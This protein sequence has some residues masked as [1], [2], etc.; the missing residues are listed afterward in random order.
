MRR[1]KG[2]LARLVWNLSYILVGAVI[3][4]G[5][6]W[7]IY[8]TPRVALVAVVG[9]VLG[10]GIVLLGRRLRWPSII[11]GAVSVIAYVLVVVPVAIPTALSSPLRIIRGVGEGVIGIVVG[12]KQLLTLTLPVGDY[13]A[14]LVPLLVVMLFGTLI[15]TLLV[16]GT[17]RFSAAA[18][19]VVVLMAAF[20][21]VFGSSETGDP[22]VIGAVVVPAP[23][24][25]LLSTV[26]VLVSLVWLVGSARLTRARALRLAQART[27]GV[28]QGGESFWLTAR[29]QALAIVLVGLA[30]AGGIA[31]APVAAGW[32]PRQ[33]LRDSVDPLIVVQQQTSP[34]SRY[35]AN[36]E[37]AAYEAE[38]FRI[39]G[40]AAGI[41]RVRMAT[42]GQ[43][44]GQVFRSGT[45]TGDQQ[46]TRLPQAGQ[47][48]GTVELS[49]TIGEG[50]AG[51]WVPVPGRLDG[52]PSF[53]GARAEQLTD[54]FYVARSDGSAV[55]VAE[56]AGGGFG[57]TAGD[58]YS[59]QAQAEA[60]GA[61]LGDVRGGESLIDPDD[62]V[63]LVNWV[64]VQKQ[65]R[66]G[67][68]LTELVSRLRDRGYLS[69]SLVESDATQQWISA[70]D[71]QSPYVF[72]SSYS[73]HSTARIETLFTTLNAQER[74][75]GPEAD[76]ELLVSAIGDDEQFA[77]A[78][79]LLARFYGF[80]S[81]V[82][83]GTVLSSDEQN[84]S[85][86]PCVDGVCTGANVTAWVEVQ[87]PQGGWVVLDASPQ[88]A[89]APTDVAEGEEL[90]ENPTVPQTSE[91]D[92][93]DPPAAQRDDAEAT[94][95]GADD[96]LGWLTGLLGV[97]A[98]V[99][100]IALAVFLLLLPLTFLFFIKSFRRRGRRSA[101]V[102]EV[103]IVGA[104]DELLDTY[105]DYGV[106]IPTTATRSAIAQDIGR[107]AVIRLAAIVD[108]AVFAEHPPRREVRDTAWSIVDD[109]RRE[110]A[111]M[112]NFKDR[113]R[114]WISLAS[115]LRHISPRAVLVAGLSVLRK[116]ETAR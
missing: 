91:A 41:S 32:S 96:G 3:A 34:L 47:G 73:G 62:Y 35:R 64:E 57:L 76:D 52:A 77:T 97:L 25:V 108:G 115:F 86:A 112:T 2:G 14:V 46:Y 9:T 61:E 10:I 53:T 13:Q 37:G 80:E 84:P 102:P 85:V 40:D 30:V 8:S 59:V 42:L 109:E 29:R 113:V 66:T 48:E 83:L 71:A 79:A 7:P 24:E 11:I 15:A 89:I 78:A 28:R 100:T 55:D 16:T 5:L 68:G 87:S 107:P 27:E 22:L 104:W 105:V 56:I 26:L 90:P 110:L 36:F 99:G 65:P 101:P 19:P 1:E 44:D 45:R 67:D 17:A 31:I 51:V 60:D 18:V 33:A 116:E 93:L 12:W 6:A 114:A 58:R 82:V 72:Q 50:F 95:S 70:L 94:D 75:V 21:L 49:V 69:H 39:N 4:T 92:V 38:L 103:A 63:A 106:D 88:F 20:G 81:R 43:Y 74:L 98:V 23:R 54:H 111:Q